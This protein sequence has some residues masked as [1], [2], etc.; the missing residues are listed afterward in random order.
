MSTQ[1]KCD[2]VKNKKL[3]PTKLALVSKFYKQ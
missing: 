1:Y 2:K 3:N